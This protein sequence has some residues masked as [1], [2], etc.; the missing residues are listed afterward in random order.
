[1][2]KPLAV[3]T[4]TFILLSFAAA[5]DSITVS[6]DSNSS[7]KP[8]TIVNGDFDECPWQ[9][10]VLNGT[11]Y[12][13]SHLRKNAG[14]IL[15]DSASKTVDSKLWNGVGE[16]W[17]TTETKLF[18]YGKLYDWTKKVNGV[19]DTCAVNAT[20]VST[21]NALNNFSFIEMNGHVQSVF[22]QDLSTQG[23]DVIRWTLKHARRNDVEERISVQIGAPE[24][25]S[26]GNLIPATS[27]EDTT[28]PLNPKIKQEGW[29]KFSYNGVTNNDSNQDRKSV[30]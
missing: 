2:K 27:K 7:Y 5:E 24:R 3:L 9:G 20:Y 14:K 21:F 15:S 17:N 18:G 12:S 8:T 25:D 26:S 1:M 28:D 29:A 13:A 19:Y 10:F 16:G 22:Y 23:K 30:V 11:T 6:E 4:G